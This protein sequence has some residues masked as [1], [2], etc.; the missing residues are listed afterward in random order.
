VDPER[1][2]ESRAEQER[3]LLALAGNA[4]TG[5]VHESIDHFEKVHPALGRHLRGSVRAGSF[6]LYDLSDRRTGGSRQ[7]TR[8]Q[9]A[10]PVLSMLAASSRLTC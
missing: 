6:C 5:R 3:R 7:R 4:L 1:G 8:Q 9:I 10:R 2:A